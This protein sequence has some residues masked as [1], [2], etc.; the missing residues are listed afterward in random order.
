MLLAAG[1]NA[2]GQLGIGSI[3]DAH[4]W[5]RA[6]LPSQD[7]EVQALAAG[8]NHA[9]ALASRP[10]SKIL[11][12]LCTGSNSRGQLC[13]NEPSTTFVTLSLPPKWHS[14]AVKSIAACWDTSFV[15]LSGCGES[16]RLVTF[17]ANDFGELGHSQ[18]VQS[19]EPYEVPLADVLPDP[20]CDFD[21]EAVRTGLRHVLAILRVRKTGERF[22]IGWGAARKGQI[23]PFCKL[24]QHNAFSSSRLSSYFGPEYYRFSTL[25]KADALALS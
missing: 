2:C 24:V 1:S 18:H 5:T 8:A 21:I 15:V 20:T 19:F 25:A 11:E 16:D 22:I 10:G 23:G 14:F 9:L 7:S 12:L 13:S 3:E 6:T 4:G 17:G